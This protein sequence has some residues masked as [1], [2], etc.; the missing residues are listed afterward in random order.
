MSPV[1]AWIIL[2][3]FIAAIVGVVVWFARPERYKI[4]NISSAK[5]RRSPFFASGSYTGNDTTSN[6]VFNGDSGGSCDTG[7]SSSCD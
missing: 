7:S 1:F 6:Y 3:V 5:S 2:I 4:E